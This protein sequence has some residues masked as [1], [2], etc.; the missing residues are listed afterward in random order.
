MITTAFSSPE[1]EKAVV[2][3]GAG[4]W[5]VGAEREDAGGTRWTRTLG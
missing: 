1:R 4:R 5:N 2:I 3:T